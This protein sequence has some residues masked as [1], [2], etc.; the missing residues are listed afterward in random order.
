MISHLLNQHKVI[1]EVP[2]DHPP[3]NWE[4]A[5][6]WLP[7]ILLFLASGFITTFVGATAGA[8]AG[9]VA[10]TKIAERSRRESLRIQDLRMNNSA[11]VLSAA[12]AS[13]SLTYKKQ[14]TKDMIIQYLQDR[15]TY[16]NYLKDLSNGKIVSPVKL[17]YDFCI[18]PPLNNDADELKKLLVNEISPEMKT[19]KKVLQLCRSLHS[20][21]RCIEQRTAEIEKLEA[22]RGNSSDDLYASKYFG[23]PDKFGNIDERYFSTMNSIKLQLDSSIY[24]SV[25]VVEELSE[26]GTEIARQIGKEK[27]SATTWSFSGPE[28]KGLIPDKSEFPD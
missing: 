27:Q 17:R 11:V 6:D 18:L 24:F 1:P 3:T 8:C 28:F 21:E 19:I 14:L 12:I 23:I 10:A 26:R 4:A 16:K 13:H 22:L 25:C 2:T 9:A 20:L 15:T 7:P 5:L